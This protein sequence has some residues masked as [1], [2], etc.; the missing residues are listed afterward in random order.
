MTG[1]TAGREPGAAGPWRLALRLARRDLRGDRRGF[2]VF[3][4]C[5][6]LGVATIAAIGIAAGSVL[7]SVAR[8]SRA[9]LGGDLLITSAGRPLAEGELAALLPPATRVSRGVRTHAFVGVGGRSLAVALRAVDGAWPLYGRAELEPPL[10]LRR[11]LADRGA[12]ADPLLASRLGIAVGD[13]LRLGAVELELRALLRREPD[14]L[15]GFMDIGPRLLVSEATLAASGLMGPGAVASW[16]YLLALPE[17]TDAER[18]AEALE[19]RARDAP[20]RLRRASRV[21]PRVA[22]FADPLTS[23]LTVAGLAVL[24]T[25]AL[26][27]ALAAAAYLDG[28][29]RTIAILKAVGAGRADI[30][31]VLGLQLALLALLGIAGGLAIG[32]AVPVAGLGFLGELLPWRVTPLVTA[33]PLLLA[34][35]VGG[36]TVLLC[37]WRPLARAAAVTP[38]VL[39]RGTVAAPAAGGWVV[40][41]LLALLLAVL[42]TLSVP[43]LRIGLGFALAVPPALALLLLLA[44]GLQRLARRTAGLARGHWRLALAAV[45]R[46]G[47]DARGVIVALGAGLALLTMVVLAEARLRVEVADRLPARTADMFLIDIQPDQR[48][49]LRRLVAATE[50]A[51]LLQSAPVVRARVTGIKGR[52]VEIEAIDEEVRWTVQADRALTWRAAPPEAGLVA[53]AWWPEDYA[54]PPLVSVEERVAEGYGVTVGD[55]LRFNVLGRS[56]EAEIANI[57][58]RIDWSRGRIDFVFVFAPGVLERAPQSWVAALALP[59]AAEAAF[60]DALARELPN[61]TPVSMREVVARAADILGR[62]GLGVRLV[63]GLALVSGVLVLAAAVTASRRRH[64]YEAVLLKTLGA[65]RREVLAL[66]VAE[67]ALLGGLAALAGLIL[68]GLGAWVVLSAVLDLGMVPATLPVAAVLAG[69]LGLVLAVGM[70]GTLRLL[71]VPAGRILAAD[72]PA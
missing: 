55:R 40:P 36:V 47:G 61:V 24:L 3:V 34:A 67:Y 52:P 7:G 58:P 59:P 11:A 43:R 8:D 48:A 25:G 21:L 19:R 9:L 32:T 39:L 12:V 2:L 72:A 69:G 70:A 30:L 50:G 14:R 1:A 44:A 51:V 4:A 10:D 57:R 63:A 60:L 16:T 53:G 37:V 62:I 13:R 22:H 20:W 26:G 15:A 17:G 49:T 18:V 5:L 66:Y 29:R 31:R 64:R 42:A 28:R 65:T 33:G 71:R 45:C 41:L 35:A 23:Y 46:P 38:A 27:I 56:I 54:G 68:G 6:A